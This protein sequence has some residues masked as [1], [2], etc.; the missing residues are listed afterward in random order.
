MVCSFHQLHP[1]VSFRYTLPLYKCIPNGFSLTLL[2]APPGS[3]KLLGIPGPRQLQWLRDETT[4]GDSSS[5]EIRGRSAEM[6]EE[7]MVVCS[8]FLASVLQSQG[9]QRPTALGC[10][11]YR[12]PGVGGEQ[13]GLLHS[14]HRESR[15][16]VGPFPTLSCAVRVDFSLL[17]SVSPPKCILLRRQNRKTRRYGVLDMTIE[18]MELTPLEQDDDDDD[19]TLFDASHPRSWRRDVKIT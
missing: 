4:V 5:M 16:I 9:P 17:A 13:L 14:R 18:N 2:L 19:T 6:R 8:S 15:I 3:I 11:R 10:S 1:R 7:T 12:L